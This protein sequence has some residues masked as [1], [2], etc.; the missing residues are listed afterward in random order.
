M[1]LYTVLK[2]TED[3][4]LSTLTNPEDVKKHLKKY[5]VDSIKWKFKHYGGG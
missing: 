5:L 4:R 2:E 3:Y 1:T